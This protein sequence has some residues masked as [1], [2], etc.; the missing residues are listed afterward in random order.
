[1][2]PYD[3]GH[4]AH[5]Q[6]FQTTVEAFA[7]AFLLEAERRVGD[8]LDGYFAYLEA[9]HQTQPRSRG[10]HAIELLTIGL[11]RRE[12]GP[13]VL[14]TPA[15]SVQR[16]EEMWYLRSKVPECKPAADA[17]R[18]QLF[19]EILRLSG[20]GS[21]KRVDDEAL[22]RWLAATG[23]FVQE[24]LRMGPWLSGTNVFWTAEEFRNQ[25]DDLAAW[26]TLAAAQALGAWTRGVEA[27]R[28]EVI[29]RAEAREDLLLITRTEPLYHLNMVGA[30]VM[31]R[32]FL[33]G[34]AMRSRK[35]VLVPGCLRV[36]NDSKCHGRHEGLDISCTR[37]DPAC[38]VAALD[39]LAEAHDFRV[40]VVPHASSF[41]AW[42]HHWQRDP[43][44]A[45]VAVACPLHLVPGGYEMRALGL[46]AQCVMLE[47]SGCKR[48][49]DAEGVPTRV[50]H[51]RLLEVVAGD[52]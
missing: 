16:L 52:R 20:G 19:R 7:D 6:D 14:A 21:P 30:L 25:T 29:E 32:G 35:V 27:F 4:R 34:Y 49:W 12:V 38:E 43:E 37:C 39:R 17:V 15:Q 8:L 51:K 48:H 46:Q 31:N 40:F 22:V 45:L 47:Y 26:F 2:R 5:S 50:D 24:A 10:E 44:T 1:M 11:L 18:G 3:I 33:P 28:R 9:G 42:L 23:E 13:L 36:H 41:T